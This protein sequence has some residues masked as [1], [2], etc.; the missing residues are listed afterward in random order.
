MTTCSTLSGLLFYKGH[1]LLAVCL[2]VFGV[3]TVFGH[4][5]VQYAFA[6]T[7]ENIFE[8]STDCDISGW[9]SLIL[10]DVIL[11][12]GLSVLFLAL[13]HILQKEQAKIMGMV[14]TSIDDSKNILAE[15]SRM[16]RQ[17]KIYATQAFKN[18]LGALLLC[19]GMLHKFSESGSDDWV[20]NSDVDK[21]L[22]K[23]R[24]IFGRMRNTIHLA[25]GTID[26]V[27]LDEIAK[28][29]TESEDLV[30]DINRISAKYDEIKK[31]MMYLADRL[32]KDTDVV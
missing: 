27:R 21:L 23:S 30:D 4:M 28:F 14:E 17:I 24:K 20:M 6:H 19:F 3:V 9:V 5:T 32:S 18:D 13:T 11:G 10:G 7:C 8:V 29:L 15:Q 16:S 26:P 1:R 12:I 2:I 25:V 22:G 31:K